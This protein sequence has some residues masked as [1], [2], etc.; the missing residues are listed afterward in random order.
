MRVSRW[1]RR[2][3]RRNR[4]RTDP[5]VAFERE[6]RLVLLFSNKDYSSEWGYHPENKKFMS[7]D[8][9]K[10]AVNIVVSTVF[11]RWH[12]AVDVL[13]GLA[14]ASFAGFA[15]PRLARI[16]DAWRAKWGLSSAW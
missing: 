5:R 1:R 13:A 12:Y 4:R 7:V 14:L 3:N 2:P 8:N 10:F 15:A 6:G 11:L 9:T 16:E